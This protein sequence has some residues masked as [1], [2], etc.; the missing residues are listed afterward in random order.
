[1]LALLGDD[2][3]AKSSTLAHQSEFAMLD[4][5]IPVLNP[6]NIYD[7]LEYGLFGWELSRF[8]GLWVSMKCITSIVD[9]TASIQ[10][11]EESFNFI[12]P[13]LAK[14][15][16]NVHI[17]PYDNM[18]EQEKRIPSLKLPLAVEFAKKNNI[19]KVI[20]KN[21]FRWLRWNLRNENKIYFFAILLNSILIFPLRYSS[22][23][24]ELKN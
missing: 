4:A 6:S 15:Q 1:M 12:K 3:T 7:L 24:F 18:L 21:G 2:H 5:Q 10:I 23:F 13:D 19:N 14:E 16:L 8:S 17:R 11:D 9:S 20:W 22:H